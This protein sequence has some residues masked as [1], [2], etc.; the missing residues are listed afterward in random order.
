MIPPRWGRRAVLE[1]LEASRRAR[2]EWHTRL[3]GATRSRPRRAQRTA[4]GNPTRLDS[5]RTIRLLD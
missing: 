1:A 4:H 5:A 2:R 3:P